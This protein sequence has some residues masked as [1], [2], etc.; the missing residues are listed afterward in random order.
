[1]NARVHVA[2]GV[3]YNSDKSEVLISKRSDNQH[4]AGFWEFPGGKVESGEDVQTALARE[5]LEEVGIVVEQA[6]RLKTIKHNYSDK[7]VLLDVWCIN[8][9]SGKVVSRENQ[10]VEW[11]PTEQLNSYTFPEANKYIISSISL[12]YIYLISQESY[13]DTSCLFSVLKEC[14]TAGLKIF[15]LRLK[16]RR[17]YQ[18]LELVKELKSLSAHYNAKLILNGSAEDIKDYNVDGVHLNSK[19]LFSYSSRPINNSYILGASCHN[20]EE[21]RQAS[22]L[23]VDYVFVSPV[24]TTKSHQQTKPMG[25]YKFNELTEKTNIPV[26]ALGGLSCKDNKKAKSSGA[27]GVA[28]I[29]AVWDSNNP[30]KIIRTC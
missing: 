17:D 10:K 22:L 24:L 1:M 26:Y 9:W 25:W 6:K 28:M 8:D 30:G 7:N 23:Q 29:S 11:V 18:Y 27:H 16:P 5:L 15:Q 20:E 4:L 14:F 13:V 19:K 12:P 2:V 3:I 21:L